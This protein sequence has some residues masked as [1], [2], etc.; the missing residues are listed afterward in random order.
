MN[1]IETMSDEALFGRDF[2]GESWA[3]WRVLL[4]SLFG[5]EMGDR[6][7]EIFTACTGRQSPP[8]EPCR[9]GWIV[10]GRRSGKSRVAALIAVFLGCFRHYELARGERGVVLVIAAD[11]RQARVIFRYIR[12]LLQSP[13]LAK[14]VER[15]TA[16]I[17][18]LQ[19][20]V[21]IEVATASHRTIRGYTVVAA[22]LDEIAF[23]RSE[24]SA[25]PDVEI[26]NAIRPAL[27]GVEGSMLLAL[28]SPY[29]RK[30]VLWKQ[31]TRHFAKDGDPVLCWQAPTL[32][33]NPS[34]SAEIVE[35][36][37]RED[38]STARAEWGAEFRSD[39]EDLFDF[40]AL[41]R[42]VVPDRIELPPVP[43]LSYQAFVDPSGGR[44]DSFTVSVAHKDGERCIV[45]VA[46]A[47]RAPFNPSGVVEECADLL[48]SYRISKVTGDRY[49]GEWPRE[50]FRS[51]GVMYEVA[52]KPK[53]DLYLAMVSAV[54][55]EQI[56]LPEN[57]Q[58]LRE[59]RSLERRRG[60]SGRDRVDHPAGGF[61]DLANAIA[62]VSD[63]VLGR[64]RGLTPADLYGPCAA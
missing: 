63:L 20:G 44:R 47:W 62:G 45:D 21:S 46:R 19:G 6:D 7:N 28:S 3:A 18:E 41:A 17:I 61:D 56:E 48:R 36:A 38:E 26:V 15:E 39:L 42:C 60:S 25:S 40:D 13:L 12:G 37:Y 1:I 33:M 16:E 10:C 49:A 27:A 14:R 58:M 54:N 64:T 34:L 52:P 51:V 22:C 9:E 50:A 32:T 24:D 55:G 57:E 31:H 43:D 5:L 4:R 59:L 23:W 35:N 29:A 11:R 2:A 53:S 8:S 30:G